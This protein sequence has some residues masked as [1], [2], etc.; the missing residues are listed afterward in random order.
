MHRIVSHCRLSNLNYRGNKSI[1]VLS[2]SS[3]PCAASALILWAWS[4]TLIG[5]WIKPCHKLTM[6]LHIIKVPHVLL[7][8]WSELYQC[9]LFL[10]TSVNLWRVRLPL[11][12]KHFSGEVDPIVTH[13][14]GANGANSLQL[15]KHFFFTAQI[16]SQVL[17]DCSTQVFIRK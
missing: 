9:K 14:S 11:L 15:L 5:R 4:R 12:E 6:L 17:K 2:L 10:L 3:S 1:C 8:M 7:R 16:C 13:F